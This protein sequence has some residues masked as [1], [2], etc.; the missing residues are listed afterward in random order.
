MWA[1]LC[2]LWPRGRRH[3]GESRSQAHLGQTRPIL[4]LFWPCPGHGL[5]SLLCLP[6]G[7]RWEEAWWPGP[8]RKDG[9]QSD[10][11]PGKRE[12][13]GLYWR[14]VAEME[15]R[16]QR[17]LEGNIYG[18]PDA[19]DVDGEEQGQVRRGSQVWAASEGTWCCQLTRAFWSLSGSSMAGFPKS[20]PKSL[21]LHAPLKQVMYL[22]QGPST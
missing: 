21:V 15:R 4:A 5:K 6:R 10:S 22:G 19:L 16:E 18:R 2:H 17:E 8:S 7:G 20:D 3:G 14:V 1:H 11:D 13:G 12:S 9:Q